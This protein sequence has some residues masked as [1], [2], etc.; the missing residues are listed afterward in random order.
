M[1]KLMFLVLGLLALTACRREPDL[2]LYEEANV[3]FDLPVVDLELEVYWNYEIGFDATYDWRAEWYYGWD[4]TDRQIFGEIGYTEPTAFNLR[5]YYTGSVPYAPHTSVLSDRIEGTTFQGRYNWGFWDILV[6][7]DIMTLDGVQSLN[8][9]ETTSLDYV[10]AY[11]NQSM[12]SSRYQAPRYTRSFY[13]PEALFTAYDQA[14]EINSN[15]EGF[16]YDEA[17]GVWVKKLPMVLL[18]ITYIYLTQVILHNNRGRISSIDGSSNLSGMARSVTLNTGQ[19]GP[20]AITVYYK[21]RLK[22]DCDKQ[23]ELVDIVGGRL[24]TFGLC[25]TIANNVRRAEELDDQPRHYMDVTMQFNNGMDST[26]VFDVTDQ[27]RRRYKGGVITVELDMDTVPIPT[28]KGGSGFNA[29]V[30]DPEEVTHVI[31]M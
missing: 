15:L 2:H 3:T 7:N 31:E 4:E 24:M 8:F 9:D 10:T 29:V 20:D 26:F 12:Q 19:A 6:W 25:N 14:I 23:G 16:E 27:V 1:R 21:S 22:K 5:R 17:R 11:T 13:E 18:P 30:L 28:R